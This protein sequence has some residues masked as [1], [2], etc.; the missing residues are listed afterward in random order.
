MFST[1]VEFPVLCRTPTMGR[2][3]LFLPGGQV[4]LG[5]V[6][7]GTLG[8]ALRWAGAVM[9]MRS[10]MMLKIGKKWLVYCYKWLLLDDFGVPPF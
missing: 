4:H 9:P 10:E 8:S 7:V 2:L 6:V 3:H 5:E 1:I